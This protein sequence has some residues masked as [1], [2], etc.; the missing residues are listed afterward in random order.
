M[1]ISL[2]VIEALAL[3]SSLLGAYVAGLV[4]MFAVLWNLASKVKK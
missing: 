2:S 1:S 4:T 3:F